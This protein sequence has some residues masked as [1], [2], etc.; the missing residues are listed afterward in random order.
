MVF[1]II[2]D[3]SPEPARLLVVA[4]PRSQEAPKGVATG[5]SRGRHGLVDLRGRRDRGQYGRSARCVA[6]TSE[7]LPLQRHAARTKQDT[8]CAG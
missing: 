1:S 3:R 5:R 7:A 6:A 4:A 8:T 2:C